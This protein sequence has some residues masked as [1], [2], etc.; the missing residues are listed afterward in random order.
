MQI[1]KSYQQSQ[2][3][4][5]LASA[6]I[7][8]FAPGLYSAGYEL[9]NQRLAIKVP[10]ELVPLGKDILNLTSIIEESKQDKGI[11]N[12][13]FNFFDKYELKLKQAKLEKLAEKKYSVKSVLN[14]AGKD[15]ILWSILGLGFIEIGNA[16]R[17]KNNSNLQNVN[18]K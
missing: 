12:Q 6:A 17:Q 13:I 15:F 9:Y 18:N 10:S 16:F 8:G 5:D 3:K 2:M 7:I 4:R 1:D 14:R 11:F